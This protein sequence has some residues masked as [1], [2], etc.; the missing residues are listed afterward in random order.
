MPYN[1]LYYF[2]YATKISF[3]SKYPHNTD[4]TND[5]RDVNETLLL[6]IDQAANVIQ[7]LDGLLILKEVLWNNNVESDHIYMF[8][9][10]ILLL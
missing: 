7:Y 4:G 2:F 5:T 6:P 8:I 9:L 1:T 3:G 10:N